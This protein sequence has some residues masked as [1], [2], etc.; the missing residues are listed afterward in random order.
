MRY[1]VTAV[2]GVP[3]GGLD[4]RVSTAYHVLDTDHCHRVVA[5]YDR[6]LDLLRRRRAHARCAQLNHEDGGSVIM[7]A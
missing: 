5:T 6:G 4:R 1:I 2:T 3:I 7:A